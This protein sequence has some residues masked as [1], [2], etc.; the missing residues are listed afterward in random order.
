MQIRTATEHRPDK[1]YFVRQE[2]AG[3]CMVAGVDKDGY[4]VEQQ[5]S[6]TLGLYSFARFEIRCGG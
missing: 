4:S 6:S 1:Q 3:W 2:E 5:L